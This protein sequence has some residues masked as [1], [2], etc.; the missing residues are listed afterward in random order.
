MIAV[1]DTGPLLYLSLIDQV[2]L[3]PQIFEK[4]LVPQAVADEL[5]HPATPA[6]ASALIENC[7]AWVEI[8]YVPKIDSSSSHLDK[9]EQQAIMLALSTRGAVLLTDDAEARNLATLTANIAASGTIGLLYEA[10]KND[11]I[12]FT[13]TNFEECMNQLLA[14]NFHRSRSLLKTIETLSREL[15][16]TRRMSGHAP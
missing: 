15:H 12:P 11:R 8:C 7:P 13:A 16:D 4:V 2:G 10:A 5:S 3:L 1:A 9:G 14:T 6:K